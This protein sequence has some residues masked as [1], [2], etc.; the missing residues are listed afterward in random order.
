MKNMKCMY[1]NAH[2]H[3]EQLFVLLLCNAAII[4]ITF[5]VIDVLC[6]WFGVAH[7]T[8]YYAKFSAQIR[9]RRGNGF[10]MHDCF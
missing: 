8:T 9:I 10:Q 2:T 5:I 1:S 3:G 6:Q 4:I 7:L